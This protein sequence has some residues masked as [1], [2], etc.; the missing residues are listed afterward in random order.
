MKR[1]ILAGEDIRSIEAEGLTEDKVLAQLEFF[2]KG[3]SPVRL[4][5]A[6]MVGDG[7]T[8]IPEEKMEELMAIHDEAA[9]KGRMLKFVPASGAASRMFREWYKYYDNRSFDSGTE[10]GT[11]FTLNL[12]RFAFYDDLK[13]TVSREGYGI[14]DLIKDRKFSIILE[15]ILTAKGLNYAHLPKALLKFHSYA[16]HNRTSLEEH[17]VEAALYVRDA[18]GVCRVH[19]TVSKEHESDVENYFASVRSYYENNCNV[20]F[21]FR[22]STQ[23]SSTNTIAVDMDNRPFRD[24]EGML[25]FRPGGHGALLKNL[26]A[27]DGDIIFIKNIDNIVPDRLK[28]ITVRYK[29]ILGGYLVKLQERMFEYLR[30]LSS[31]RVDGELL[32]KA[33]D[34]CERELNIVFH[35]EF[36]GFP[37]AEKKN[38]I[39]G[40][41]N[42]PLR[43][44]GVVKNVG[45]PGGG[46][47]WTEE[48]DGTQSLQIIESAQVDMGSEQQKSVWMS[49]THFNPVDLVC[50]LK[51]YTSKKFD[52]EKFVEKKAILITKKSEEGRDLKALEIPGLWNGSMARWN[53]VFVEVPIET[54]NPVKTVNDLLRKQHMG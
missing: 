8:V 39:I 22:L 9:G 33:A 24:S 46:P 27:V 26:N 36:D 41:L 20:K 32:S 38:Y 48:E 19:F 4:N 40:R 29:K 34:F 12:N 51:D 54:F 18:K 25:V 11:D 3:A 17:L 31:G 13:D 6:C 15:Y 49:A 16:G 28:G 30:L 2:K 44:C 50:G 14:E 10:M 1:P 5:R 53:T 43:V 7:I 47:F 37:D 52:L 35:P 45:E 42:R 21:D 23:L